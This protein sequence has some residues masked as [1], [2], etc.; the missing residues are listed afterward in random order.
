MNLLEPQSAQT[1]LTYLQQQG[2]YPDAF[3]VKPHIVKNRGLE[4][5]KYSEYGLCASHPTIV[6]IGKQ[7]NYEFTTCHNNNADEFQVLENIIKTVNIN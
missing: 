3:G 2:D 5:V 6:V 7:H 1:Y 4:M